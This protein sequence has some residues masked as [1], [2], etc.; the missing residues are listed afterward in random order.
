VVM[1]GR[2]AYPEL[3]VIVV[4]PGID[5]AIDNCQA[6]PNATSNFGDT[7]CH[8]AHLNRRAAV[9]DRAIAELTFAVPTPGVS[10][11]VSHRQAVITAGSCSADAAC[12]ANDRRRHVAAG[13]RGIAE[14]ANAILSPS[15]G[16]VAAGARPP[17]TKERGDANR[18][19]DAASLETMIRA[20]YRYA[21]FETYANDQGQ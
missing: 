1:L 12:Q 7:A 8:A 18:K 19:Y 14:F 9:D 2:G 4:A 3:A 6:V 5:T 17:N 21:A 15:H 11:A 10:A 16:R 20:R 13:R